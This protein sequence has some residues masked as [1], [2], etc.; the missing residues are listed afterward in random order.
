M[1]NN[2]FVFVSLYGMCIIFA[3]TN[4]EQMLFWVAGMPR[5]CTCCYVLVWLPEKPP[6]QCRLEVLESRDSHGPMHSAYGCIAIF[7]VQSMSVECFCTKSGCVLFMKPWQEDAPSMH[8]V[9]AWW[10]SSDPK[11]T[12]YR[13][14]RRLFILKCTLVF[15]LSTFWG[16]AWV[17]G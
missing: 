3:P 16:R 6:Y 15:T 9:D 10:I 5:E 12:C 2:Y 7:I 11:P 17:Q 8:M 13:I 14:F 1:P 4:A